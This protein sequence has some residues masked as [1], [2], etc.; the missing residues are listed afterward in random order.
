MSSRGRYRSEY[1]R[2]LVS[3]HEKRL[4]NLFQ[5]QPIALDA[6]VSQVKMDVT[7]QLNLADLYSAKGLVTVITGG[8]TGSYWIPRLLPRMAGEGQLELC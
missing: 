4:L 2:N 7:K 8:G 6:P 3:F 5:R 1:V